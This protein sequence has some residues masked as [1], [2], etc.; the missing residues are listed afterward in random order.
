MHPSLLRLVFILDGLEAL[1]SQ[2]LDFI[3]MKASRNEIMESNFDEKLY[4]LLS[5]RVRGPYW[6]IY[7]RGLGSTERAQQG[8]IFFIEINFYQRTL[9]GRLLY[10]NLNPST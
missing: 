1:V 3:V 10:V 2:I 9:N 7:S 6:G 8:P 5:N 4:H